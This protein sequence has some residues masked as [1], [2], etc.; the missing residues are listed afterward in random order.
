MVREEP[1]P[2][3]KTIEVTWIHQDLNDQQEKKK[4]EK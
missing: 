3:W 4:K 1:K 2:G